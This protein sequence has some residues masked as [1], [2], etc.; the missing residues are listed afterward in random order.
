MDRR[1]NICTNHK[2]VWEHIH[3]AENYEWTFTGKSWVIEHGSLAHCMSKTKKK[4]V[5]EENI[6]SL[7]KSL[8][9]NE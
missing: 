5:R 9:E 6:T 8:R 7:Y 1:K 4:L 3:T 2:L